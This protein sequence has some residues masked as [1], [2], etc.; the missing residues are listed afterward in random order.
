MEGP[1]G[2]PP[3]GRKGRGTTAA[4]ASGAAAAASGAVRAAVAASPL[5]LPETRAAVPASPGFGGLAGRAA[6]SPAASYAASP[7]FG[8]ASGAA[9]NGRGAAVPPS[10]RAFGSASGAAGNGANGA[11]GAN[12]MNTAPTYHELI[13]E[14][15]SSRDPRRIIDKLNEIV[16]NNGH[17]PNNLKQA[18]VMYAAKGFVRAY[19]ERTRG[20]APIPPEFD[21]ILANIDRRSL[22]SVWGDPDP[23]QTATYDTLRAALKIKNEATLRRLKTK[24]NAATEPLSFDEQVALDDAIMRSDMATADLTRGF[25]GKFVGSAKQLANATLAKFVMQEKGKIPLKK[26]ISEILHTQEFRNSISGAPWGTLMELNTTLSSEDPPLLDE[27]IL[28]PALHA[29]ISLDNS[30]SENLPEDAFTTAISGFLHNLDIK[31]RKARVHN[32]IDLLGNGNESTISEWSPRGS[33]LYPTGDTNEDGTPELVHICWFTEG[34]LLTLEKEY[35]EDKL[36]RNIAGATAIKNLIAAAAAEEAKIFR[37]RGGAEILQESLSNRSGQFFEGRD[38]TINTATGVLER[39]NSHDKKYPLRGGRR[40]K[41]TMRA[42]HG[43]KHSKKT[44]KH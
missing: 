5:V 13:Q 4:A 11:N 33:I 32:Y 2:R 18:V 44:R 26:K 12:L 20:R 29:I 3:T 39:L 38:A 37:M 24:L 42:K 25:A 7:G 23:D 34:A 10:P 36:K 1:T 40:H 17:I 14:I 21:E 16:D 9:G 27:S 28:A 6:L 41:R 43:K 8:S 30:I 35:Y 15:I 19:Q 22:A 31:I